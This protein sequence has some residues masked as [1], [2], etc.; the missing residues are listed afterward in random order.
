VTPAEVAAL[1]PNT[2]FVDTWSLAHA[3]WGGLFSV[4]GVEPLPAAAM[5][6]AFDYFENPMK[7]AYPDI[8]SDPSPD[9][10]ENQ[11]GDLIAFMAGYIGARVLGRTKGAWATAGVAGLTGILWMAAIKDR[12]T[13]APA[14]LPGK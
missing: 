12:K 14:W 8:W 3:V 2:R 6:V 10:W 13:Q 5:A 4:V 1:K 11:A 9:S 7:E